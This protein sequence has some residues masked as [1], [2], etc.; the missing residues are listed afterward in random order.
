M[1]NTMKN[2]TSITFNRPSS[3]N[4]GKTGTVVAKR[5][6]ATSPIGVMLEGKAA[7]VWT[8]AKFLTVNDQITDSVT[9]EGFNIGD[10]V[11]N[12]GRGSK[13]GMTG[14]VK[15]LRDAVTNV[16][17][18]YVEG[19]T[20]WCKHTNLTVYSPSSDSNDS[21]FSVGD[22]VEYTKPGMKKTGSEGT[23]KKFRADGRVGVNFRGSV[24]TWCDADN[25]AFAGDD[26]LDHNESWDSDDWNDDFNDSAD[27]VV[28]NFKGIN[29]TV[30]KDCDVSITSEGVSVN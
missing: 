11:T 26:M 10:T 7:I 3:T 22:L 24:I 1:K 18:E 9:V 2:G 5:D 29:I 21:I 23:V 30:S 4:H 6:K 20:T 16:G 14:T 25:L 19:V 8:A 12:T 13:S 28:I 15:K 27:S 17:V